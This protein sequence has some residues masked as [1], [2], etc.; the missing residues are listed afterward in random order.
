MKRS[1]EFG[2]EWEYSIGRIR[3][4]SEKGKNDMIKLY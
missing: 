2:N 1:H 4:I 3:V